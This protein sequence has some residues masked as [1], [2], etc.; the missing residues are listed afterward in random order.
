MP[1]PEKRRTMKAMHGGSVER[2]SSCANHLS[3]IYGAHRVVWAD[4]ACGGPVV[5]T[6]GEKMFLVHLS[7]H[8]FLPPC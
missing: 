7:F 5:S 3:G 1:S 4:P 2:I 6:F 8:I